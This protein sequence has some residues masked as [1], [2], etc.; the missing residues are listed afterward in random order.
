MEFFVFEFLFGDHHFANAFKLEEF[1]L[2]V[3]CI[4]RKHG[5]KSLSKLKRLHLPI[6]DLLT[7]G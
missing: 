1:I 2:L 4:Q 3:F 7:I 5:L 6:R